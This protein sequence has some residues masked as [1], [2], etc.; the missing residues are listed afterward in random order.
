MSCS[1]LILCVETISTGGVHAVTTVLFKDICICTGPL[2]F[3]LHCV[4][5]NI[6]R[7]V[8]GVQDGKMRTR[9]FSEEMQRRMEE[10]ERERSADRDRERGTAT[11]CGN[12][13][14]VLLSILGKNLE[15]SH[16]HRHR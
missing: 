5:Q 13:S 12:A 7:E 10:T 9:D 1:E 11:G 16:H 3:T 14:K 8:C 15:S 2:H 6:A 4:L